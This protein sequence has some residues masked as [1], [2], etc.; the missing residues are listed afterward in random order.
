MVALNA[1]RWAVREARAAIAGSLGLPA[2][3][4]GTPPPDAEEPRGVFVTLVD[5]SSG[6]LR[7]CIG[8]PLPVLPLAEAVR[9]AAVASAREDPRF[10]SLL[11]EEFDRIVVEVSILTPPELIAASDPEGRLASVE[12]G[13]D[14]L[15]V[16]ARGASGL[17]LP[18]VA[19]VQGWGASEFLDATCEKAGLPF[20]AWR[21]ASTV[22][23]RFRAEVFAEV[24]PNGPVA[25]RRGASSGR[26]AP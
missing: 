8:Y 2:R 6:E 11:P 21:Q 18:Q 17:L 16:R 13:R 1:G 22:V 19:V 25:A 14:G 15:I 23:E 26:S 10:P 4:T 24:E 12:V 20:A 3:P 7:G 9:G 5:L